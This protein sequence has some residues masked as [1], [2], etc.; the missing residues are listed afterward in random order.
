MTK[1]IDIYGTENCRFCAAAVAYCKKRGYPVRYHDA[2]VPVIRAEML[3]RA[4][5]AVTVPQIFIG[6]ARI[7][8]FDSLVRSDERI[9][10]LLGGN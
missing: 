9:Q 5:L 10:Q 7:G 2:G 3:D 1:K 6:E 8:G 4:P